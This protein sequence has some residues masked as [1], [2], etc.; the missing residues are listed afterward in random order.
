MKEKLCRRLVRLEEIHA[1]AIRTRE[2][3]SQ[4]SGTSTAEILRERL[5]A[6]GFEQ[7]GN[8]SLAETMGRAFGMNSSEL[9]CYL[10]ER[11][12]QAAEAVR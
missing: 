2:A 11:A 6:Q 3:C 5:R 4:P 12:A 1:L 9:R 10:Q 8:E 7:T